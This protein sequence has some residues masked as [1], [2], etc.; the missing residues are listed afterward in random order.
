MN[1][2]RVSAI[3]D[4]LVVLGVILGVLMTKMPICYHYRYIS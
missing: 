3:D 4:S 1:S 2:F